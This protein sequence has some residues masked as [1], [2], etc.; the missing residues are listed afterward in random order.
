M[1]GFNRGQQP[2]RPFYETLVNAGSTCQVDYSSRDFDN[3]LE[4][5]TAMQYRIDNLTDSVVIATWQS[6]PVPEDQGFVTIPASLNQMTWPYRDK[7]LNQVTF[8]ATYA[9]GSEVQSMAYYQLCAV[10]QAQ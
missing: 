4:A 10:F 1:S 7:Q 2:V 9:D 3:V 6:V 5:P 8:L